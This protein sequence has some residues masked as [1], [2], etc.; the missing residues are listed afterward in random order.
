MKVQLNRKDVV[1]NYLGIMMNL[2][3]NFLILPF[4][5]YFLDDSRYGLW[6]VFVSLGGIVALFDFGFNTTF[7]RNITFC[8]SGARA[9]SKESVEYSENSEPDFFLMKKVLNTC[10]VIYF[11]I[12]LVALLALS[13]FGTAYI[14]YIGGEIDGIDY[15]FAWLI[16]G[17]AIF[18]N[19]YYGYYDSFLRGVGAIATVNKLKIFARIVQI[20][21]VA[22]LMF[23]GFGIMG[24]SVAYLG[25]GLFFRV[26]AKRSFYRYHNIGNELKNITEEPAKKDIREMFTVIWHNAWR[27]GLVSLA[28]YLSNQVTVIIA[29]LYLT[30][31]ETG[32]YSLA[33]QLA[34]AVVQISSAL[35]TAYQ[36]TLQSAYVARNKGK[37][38][39]V[40]SAI[41]VSFV[42]LSILGFA[43][44]F[45]VGIPLIRLV[46]PSAVL[47][48]ALILGVGMYQIILKGRN[49]YTSYLSSTNRL[50]YTRAFVTSGVLCVLFSFVFEQFLNLGIWGLIFAQV[51]SQVIFN[52]WYW[53]LFV[54][55][56]LELS[57][58]ELPTRGTRELR[59]FFSGKKK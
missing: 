30:L 47:E 41:L 5:L 18:L 7:A 55:R 40:M 36:P 9:L 56:E 48:P 10:R 16:Y 51:L 8:W 38:K 23:S 2:G 44:L 27:D 39:D 32:A 13:I 54:H 37:I 12:S 45:L 15:I 59:S 26:T 58:L 46:K 6:N 31:A 4:L 42:T 33:V 1:W 52:A 24:A 57:V 43:A 14:Y 49:C 50:P 35:Y 28:N 29:S 20:L 21:L 17:V 53:P 19:L 11:V 25:Y 3:G 34:Q 22:I